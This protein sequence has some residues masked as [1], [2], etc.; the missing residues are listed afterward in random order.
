[1]PAT[2]FQWPRSMTS[3][4]P[5]IGAGVIAPGTSISKVPVVHVTPPAGSRSSPAAVP[6]V[7]MTRVVSTLKS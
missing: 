7:A 3:R 6:G 1:M 5:D 2:W 4:S